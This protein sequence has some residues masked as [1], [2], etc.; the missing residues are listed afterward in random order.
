MQR[1]NPSQPIEIAGVNGIILSKIMQSNYPAFSRYLDAYNHS[2]RY[3]I[4]CILDYIQQGGPAFYLEGIEQ[5]GKSWICIPYN[6]LVGG[7]QG[8]TG[9]YASVINFMLLAGMLEKFDPTR[10]D[11]AGEWL[12]QSAGE[13]AKREGNRRPAIYYHLPAW[14]E[15]TLARAEE[16]ASDRRRLKTLLDMIDREG[17]T[18]A[19]D[20]YDTDRQEKKVVSEARLI[21]AEVVADQL[22]RNGYTTKKR[23]I[24]GMRG[25]RRKCIK[26]V[27]LRRLVDEYMRTFCLEY[28]LEYRRP[29]KEQR[30]KWNLKTQTF[31]VYR[32]EQD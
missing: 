27:V 16:L 21:M 17:V 5:A 29:T 20:A 32:R 1:Y 11:N 18:A 26:A 6:K 7:Y 19:Q 15:A 12:A 8:S 31:I 23:I 13:Y 30:E 24:M 3:R 9:T 2:K 25:T 4:Q 10:G 28:A 22:N 14:N